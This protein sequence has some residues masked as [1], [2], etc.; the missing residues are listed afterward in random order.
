VRH[1]DKYFSLIGLVIS[2]S[3]FVTMLLSNDTKRKV[4][5]AVAATV[6]LTALS[7]MTYVDAD[8][9]TRQIKRVTADIT[10]LLN[11]RSMTFDQLYSELYFTSQAD[12]NEAL[13]HLIAERSV[14]FKNLELRDP[15]GGTYFVKGF[16]CRAGK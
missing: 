10:D 12:L 9:H 1:V 14:W 11:S 4:L 5:L 7:V 13:G 3:G 16:Y 6:A 15:G 2:I 8:R